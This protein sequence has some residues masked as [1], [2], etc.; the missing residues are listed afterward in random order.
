[1]VRELG[2]AEM[3]LAPEAWL[4]ARERTESRVIPGRMR[5]PSGGVTSSTPV[6]VLEIV[7]VNLAHM[8]KGEGSI[9]SVC[10]FKDYE[11]VHSSNLYVRNRYQHTIEYNRRPD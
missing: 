8:G 3:G 6:F 4:R 11:Q 7:S 1:M 9:T 2:R 10:L 5:S